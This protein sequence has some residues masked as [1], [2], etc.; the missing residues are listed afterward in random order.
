MSM[1]NLLDLYNLIKPK[2]DPNLFTTYPLIIGGTATVTK[3]DRGAWVLNLI[4]SKTLTKSDKILRKIGDS[5]FEDQSSIIQSTYQLDF[6]KSFDNKID[7]NLKI[8]EEA[9]KMRE[10]LNGYEVAEYLKGLGGE[11]LP[12]L[13][14]IDFTFE[15][16]DTKTALGRARFDFVIVST[17]EVSIE[18]K[19]ADKAIIEKGVVLC[20]DS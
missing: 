15:L 18:V 14:N 4:N 9:I 5:F 11:I 3:L 2:N 16:S 12:T 13:G 6:F 8:Q 17:Q 7:T 20:R 19:T 10:W 1:I